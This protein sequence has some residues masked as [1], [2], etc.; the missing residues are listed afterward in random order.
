MGMYSCNV[1]FFQVSHLLQFTVLSFS[2]IWKRPFLLVETCKTKHTRLVNCNNG[3]VRITLDKET[4]MV[5]CIHAL[6]V[7]SLKVGA[8]LDFGA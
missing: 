8:F 4:Y 1:F 3:V 6:H 7:F 2:Y 5:Y